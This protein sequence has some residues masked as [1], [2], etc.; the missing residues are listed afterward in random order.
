MAKKNNNLWTPKGLPKKTSIG[1]SPNTKHHSRGGGA[2]GST[3][4]K[5]YKKPYRGQGK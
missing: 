4:S 1:N 2:Q 5:N 3:T